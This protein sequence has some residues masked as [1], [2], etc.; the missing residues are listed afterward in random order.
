MPEANREITGSISYHYYEK[1]EEGE[2]Y[3]YINKVVQKLYRYEERQE[4]VQTFFM[5]TDENGLATKTFSLKNP[6][7]G[8]YT[9]EL[10]WKDGNGRV[11]K[12]SVYLSSYRTSRMK[13][14]YD[15]YHLD[16]DKNSYRLDEA[17]TVTLMNN[18]EKVTSPQSVLYMEA[19]KGIL[20]YQVSSEAEYKTS[21]TKS[22]VPNFYVAA[23]F[24]NGRAIIEC[25][26]AERPV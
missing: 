4:T 26:L 22:M 25:R 9:A 7:E 16:T 14:Q 15:W 17:V 19:Q 13:A 6:T 10:N 20:K 3:D 8:W 12:R 5:R 24:F 23:V 1:I 11:M 18:E 2:E 21:F